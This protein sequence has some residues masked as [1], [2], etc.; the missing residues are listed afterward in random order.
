MSPQMDRESDAKIDILQEDYTL[1]Y[2]QPG[3]IRGKCAVVMEPT[4]H[5]APLALTSLAV[6]RGHAQ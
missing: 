4:R 6:R 2:I 1:L 3:F 5:I